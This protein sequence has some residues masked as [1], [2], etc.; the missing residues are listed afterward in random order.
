MSPG[1]P[2]SQLDIYLLNF[3]SSNSDLLLSCSSFACSF[4]DIL[5]FV[6]LSSLD[7]NFVDKTFI[8]G[9]LGTEYPL[10]SITSNA[11]LVV[12]KEILLTNI[13]ILYCDKLWLKSTFYSLYTLLFSLSEACG[14][15]TSIIRKKYW[16][17]FEVYVE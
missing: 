7:L 3:T 16:L 1:P 8:S 14:A 6:F 15:G 12:F 4:L 10:S 17:V 5:L 11:E 9:T 2:P 13:P